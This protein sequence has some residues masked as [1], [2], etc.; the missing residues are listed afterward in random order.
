MAT[1][2]E[3]V[4]GNCVGRVESRGRVDISLTVHS[5]AIL[6]TVKSIHIVVFNDI[7]AVSV[8]FNM[9]LQIVHTHS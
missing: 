8:T 3:N 5:R 2:Y 1:M 7:R 9:L 4:C 6:K